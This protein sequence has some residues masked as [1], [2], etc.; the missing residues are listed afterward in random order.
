M[1][2]RPRDITSAVLNGFLV[3]LLSV[4]SLCVVLVEAKIFFNMGFLVIPKTIS[5]TVPSKELS[6]LQGKNTTEK[7]N[8]LG[9]TSKAQIVFYNDSGVLLGASLNENLN[10]SLDISVDGKAVSKDLSSFIDPANIL[11][12]LDAFIVKN[13]VNFANLVISKLPR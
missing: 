12:G 3:L 9:A 7:S 10:P 1:F 11:R 6:Y 4:V 8:V 2:P 13:W 5:Y